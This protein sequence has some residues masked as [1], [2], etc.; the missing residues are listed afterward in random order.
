[1]QINAATAELP[2]YPLCHCVLQSMECWHLPGKSNTTAAAFLQDVPR[3]ASSSCIPPSYTCTFSRSVAFCLDVHGMISTVADVL[4]LDIDICRLIE[5]PAPASLKSE[6]P[7]SSKIFRGLA[8]IDFK[9]LSTF[10]DLGQGAL[11]LISVSTDWVPIA[12]LL[13]VLKRIRQTYFNK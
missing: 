4:S 6:G 1:M 3:T 2:M 13:L 7:R 12:G 10:K 11:P 8:P 5:G 9:Y